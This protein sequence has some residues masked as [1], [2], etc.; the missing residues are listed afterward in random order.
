MRDEGEF[1][2][3]ARLSERLARAGRARPSGVEVH[4][5]IGDDA[6]VTEPEGVTVTSTEALVDGVHF[7]RAT[8]SMR[9]IGRKALAAALSDVAA[10]GASAGEAYVALG[11]PDDVDEAACL[12]L[13]DGLAALAVEAGTAVLGGDLT[14]SP[15]LVLAVTVVGHPA[16]ADAIVPRDGA[17]PDETLTVTGELGGAAAGLLLLERPELSSGLDAETAAA[18]ID[19]QREPAPRLA[20]GAALASAGATAMIDV[21][22]GLGADAGQIAAASGVRIAIEL[23]RVPVQDGVAEIAAAAEVEARDLAAAGGED[24]E[25]LAVV[26]SARVGDA[27]SAVSA[28]GVRLSVIGKTTSGEGVEISAADGSVSSPSGFDHLRSRTER[29][30]PG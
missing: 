5:G 28:T 29:A 3:I 6:A 11:I 19:R 14:S 10:M 18:L 27:Q 8:A 15:A 17:S 9:S 25:L 16:S 13:Y 2:L 21:S 7:R 30:E 26:P 22:D 23:D 24:Y 1:R 20:A 12:E 4:L